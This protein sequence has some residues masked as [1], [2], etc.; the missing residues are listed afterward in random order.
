[1]PAAP[2]N[3]II[4]PMTTSPWLPQLSWRTAAAAIVVASAALAWG[5]ADVVRSQVPPEHVNG[6]AGFAITPPAG[7]TSRVDDADGSRIGPVEQPEQGFAWMVVTARFAGRDSA[8]LLLSEIK[9]RPAAG[10]VRDL[11]WTADRPFSLADGTPAVLAEFD[12]RMHGREVSGW[13]LIA[14]RDAR[15][16]QVSVVAPAYAREAWAP[17]IEASLRSLRIF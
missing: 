3:F 8:A 6:A 2:P 4:P 16:I 10:P 7:W 12:Q 15:M 5:L 1:M 11:T 13:T 9:A 14:V 17:G